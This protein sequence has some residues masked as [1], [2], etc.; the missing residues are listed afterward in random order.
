[1]VG[2]GIWHTDFGPTSTGRLYGLY[3]KTNLI[4]E[5]LP[6]TSYVSS[7][8]GSGGNLIFTVTNVA[9]QG[10]YRAGVKLP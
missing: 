4:P 8:Q 5:I 6:W 3:W 7:V 1:M 10:L 2:S 9:P